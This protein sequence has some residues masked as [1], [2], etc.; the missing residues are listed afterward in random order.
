MSEAY[1]KWDE[2]KLSTNVDAMDKEHK[3]LIDIMNQ[4][5]E[6]CHCKASADEQKKIMNELGSWTEKHFAHEEVFFDQ[7]PYSQAAAHKLIHKSLLAKL[8]EYN[9][10]LQKKGK[11]PEEFFIFL[12]SW[13]T[14]HIAGIDTKYGAIAN[15]KAG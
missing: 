2:K 5:Y 15:K 4:L 11:L 14:A 10:E 6:C 9:N 3:K 1:F 8:N 12:K 13:L 7:L